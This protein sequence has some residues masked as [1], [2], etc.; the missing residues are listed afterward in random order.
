MDFYRPYLSTLLKIFLRPL[1]ENIPIA[2]ILPKV[3]FSVKMLFILTQTSYS[4]RE[5]D[6]LRVRNIVFVNFY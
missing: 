5:V 6:F 2:E 1:K 3:I 4:H